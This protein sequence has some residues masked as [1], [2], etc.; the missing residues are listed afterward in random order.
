MPIGYNGKSY[1][2]EFELMYEGVQ[3][4]RTEDKT[5]GATPVPNSENNAPTGSAAPLESIPE[6]APPSTENIP[7]DITRITV[8]P[9]PDYVNPPE[10]ETPFPRPTISGMVKGI[11]DSIK[12]WGDAIQGKVPTWAM[13]E[14][15]EYHTSPQVLEKSLDLAGLAVMGP[16][17]VASK[18]AEGTLG[19]FAGVRSAT[20]DKTK[21]YKAQNLELNGAHPDEIWQ[22]TGFF[23]GAD[24]RWRYEIPNDMSNLKSTG[25]GTT[26]SQRIG[27]GEL[28]KI[29]RPSQ[30]LT[31]EEI[32]D[33]HPDELGRILSGG[34]KLEDVLHN[35]ELFKAYPFLRNIEV[36]NI[37][38]KNGLKG[39]FNPSDNS[40]YMAPAKAD[41]F[42][43]TLQHEVQHAIQQHEG[44]ARGG[45]TQMFSSPEF[46]N[47]KAI[48]EQSMN[49]VMKEI[50]DKY[51]NAE[52]VLGAIQSKLNGSYDTM[53]PY[54][55]DNIDQHIKFAKG[56]GFYDKMYKYAVA[57]NKI[58]EL[59]RINYQKYRR[60][61]GEVEA[62]N[63]QARLDFDNTDRFLKSPRSTE[64]IPRFLQRDP[65]EPSTFK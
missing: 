27:E 20:L 33:L 56:E 54:F 62:R 8:R 35:P 51:P 61:M 22:Q 14:N 9:Q 19:S 46:L 37:E 59:E 29:K 41:S 43:S 6:G 16:A 11:Y 4:P 17:P 24:D 45:N 3:Q 12:T 13:D 31:P 25:T 39:Q 5:Q 48:F 34:Q 58:D 30:D 32:M 40:I 7:S 18:L 38:G 28:I 49:K 23:R 26:L 15:G 53:S 44:F 36:R 42:L 63:I 50:S 1:D 10:R 2:S 55:K 60:L 65:G 47:K 52:S 64:D 57:A 21:L